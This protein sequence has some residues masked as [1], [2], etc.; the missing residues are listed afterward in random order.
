MTYLGLVSG[1]ITQPRDCFASNGGGNED[2]DTFHLQYDSDVESPLEAIVRAT[3]VVKNQSQVELNPLANVIDPDALN[4]VCN[5]STTTS[6][7]IEVT[8]E[9]EGLEVTVNNEGNVW[10]SWL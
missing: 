2:P 6:S 3:A 5:S 7:N 9:Y 8:F 4:E 10:L 1:Q